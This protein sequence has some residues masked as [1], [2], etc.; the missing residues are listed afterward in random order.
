MIRV[1]Y[2]ALG[3]ISFIAAAPQNPAQPPT[4]AQ[5]RPVFLGGT[6]LVGVQCQLT[7]TIK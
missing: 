1:R 7:F 5:Q 2:L 3:L 4:Q 6:H